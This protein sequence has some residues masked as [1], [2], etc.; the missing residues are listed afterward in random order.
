MKLAVMVRRAHQAGE[1]CSSR[2]CQQKTEL[3][4][5]SRECY[6]L[7]KIGRIPAQSLLPYIVQS[8]VLTSLF[9]PSANL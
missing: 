1:E 3:V 6:V 7:L 9:L 4:N 8:L 2:L 5:S